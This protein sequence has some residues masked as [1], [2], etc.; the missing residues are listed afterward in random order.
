[1]TLLFLLW[2]IVA[3]AACAIQQRAAVPM[4][5]AGTTP[6]VAVAVNG[7]EGWFVVDTGASRTAVTPEAVT[8]FGLVLDEWTATTT[9][10]AGGIER[11]RNALPRSVTLGGMA[12][13]RRS[14]AR[15][16]T[17]RVV[18]LPR[19]EA[20]GRTIAG[21]LGR[22]FLSGF[23]LDLDFPRGTLTLLAVSGCAG[24]VPPGRFP[25]WPEPYTAI[26]VE[27]PVDNALVVPVDV[28]GTRL[29]ALLD[30]GASRTLI[31]APGMARLGL[32]LDRLK[33][34]PREVVSGAGPHAVTM[35]RH[36]FGPIRVGPDIWDAPA[37]L[38]APIP[39]RPIAD[40]LLG[41][42]WMMGRRVWIS[43]ATRQVFITR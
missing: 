30:T 31:A 33:D 1:M 2:P 43:H 12:L 10:G 41:A 20:G 32:G 29:R 11:R 27:S 34:D 6:L 16:N 37:F 8:R 7:T 15:D 25:P 21:L 14:V 5:L 26:P 4:L 28:E 42:D 3:R 36:R 24:H 23:D 40:L 13:W 35:W 19:A 38:V 17:L 39:L 9:M 22:D 18:T